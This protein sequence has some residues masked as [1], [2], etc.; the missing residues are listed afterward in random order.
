MAITKLLNYSLE[1]NPEELRDQKHKLSV[2][3]KGEKDILN[4]KPDENHSLDGL[5]TLLEDI[6]KQLTAMGYS[7]EQVYGKKLI[8]T[9]SSFSHPLDD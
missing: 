5:L 3:I 1:I 4:I 9:S 2:M 7:T 6:Q 8:K